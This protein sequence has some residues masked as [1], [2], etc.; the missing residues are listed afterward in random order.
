MDELLKIF[1][2]LFK[3]W[4][5][6]VDM[7]PFMVYMVDCVDASALPFLAQQFKVDGYRGWNLAITETQQRE[8]IKKGIEIQRKVGTPY[9]IKQALFA[10]GFTNVVINEG[11]G[12]TYNGDFNFDGAISFGGGNIWVNFGVEIRTPNPS[13]ISSE[14]RELVRLLILEYKNA[15]SNLQYLH[16]LTE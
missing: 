13:S 3:K 4:F 2:P 1:E 11:I 5:D 7:S 16:F 6:D 12:Y 9:A 14:T 15:R 8:L 10:L